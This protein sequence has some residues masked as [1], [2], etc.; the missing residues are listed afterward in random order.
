MK[1]IADETA[2]PFCVQYEQWKLARDGLRA[3]SGYDLADV[4]LGT[5]VVAFNQDYEGVTV[6]TET[7]G[8]DLEKIHGK[9]DC[10]PVMVDARRSELDSTCSCRASP[11][12]S[13]SWC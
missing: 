1:H 9:Y 11:G 4:R 7:T 10:L 2:F 12:T 13:G 6:V 5:R 8:G 3:L